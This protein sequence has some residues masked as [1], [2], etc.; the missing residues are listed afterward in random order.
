MLYPDLNGKIAVV[1][2]GSR[3]IGA[4]TAGALAES[5]V[6]VAV[7]G[8][9]EAALEEVVQ[10]VTAR[11]GRAL[12]VL[13]DCTLP[14]DV[15]RL[16]ATVLERLGVPDILLPFA[17]GNGMPVPTAQETA[18]HWREVVESNLTT[19]FMTTNAFLPAM[20][21]RGSGSIITMS[22]SAARQPAGSSAAYAAAKAG[23]I[24]FT[25]QLATEAAP[26]GIRV[27]CLAPSAIENA[28]IRAWM[29]AEQRGELAESFPLRRIGQPG[30]VASATLFLASEASSWITGV[31][32][33]IAGGKIM[34]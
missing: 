14:D 11:G 5:G 26:A 19:T 10:G 22:S 17:G 23:V 31:T 28:R 32:L 4:A 6:A 24:A 21:E 1:T 15:A 9:D 33:D 20:I 3:G 13:A 16:A 34:V 7:V 29:T 30:D 8:R 27:N 2:G 25:R 12:A 18:A